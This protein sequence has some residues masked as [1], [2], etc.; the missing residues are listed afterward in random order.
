MAFT[1][2]FSLSAYTLHLPTKMTKQ[3]QKDK[4]KFLPN[5]LLSQ[6]LSVS[7]YLALSVSLLVSTPYP[8]FISSSSL[9]FQKPIFF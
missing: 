6:F 5:A 9:A 8:V 4:I 1:V 7:H 3:K 2:R